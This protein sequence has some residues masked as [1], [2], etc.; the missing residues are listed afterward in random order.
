VA[1][2]SVSRTVAAPAVW[3]VIGADW[4]VEANL[5]TP[6]RAL[7]DLSEPRRCA[8]QSAQRTL[9]AGAGG[10]DQVS[11]TIERSR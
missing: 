10:I 6:E 11:A 1:S 4:V 8:H 5:D 7:E 3:L 2:G 9:G